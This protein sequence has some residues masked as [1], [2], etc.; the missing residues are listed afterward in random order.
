MMRSGADGCLSPADHR[1]RTKYARHQATATTA[2]RLPPPARSIPDAFR[3]PTEP[4]LSMES[5]RAWTAPACASTGELES[6][7]APDPPRADAWTRKART[8]AV[9]HPPTAGPR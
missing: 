7:P 4:R 5:R 8:I 9:E 1:A 3:V 6:L 2:D